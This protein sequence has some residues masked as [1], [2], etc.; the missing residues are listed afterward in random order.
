MRTSRLVVVGAVA[1]VGAVWVGQG[2]G[3]VP[4]SFMSGDVTWAVVGAALLVVAVALL[5]LGGGRST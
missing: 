4:G 1:L 5:V 3:Y 2:L